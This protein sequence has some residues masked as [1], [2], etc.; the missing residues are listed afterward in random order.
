[1]IICIQNIQQ[2]YVRFIKNP[3]NIRTTRFMSATNQLEVTNVYGIFHS[4]IAEFAFF[5]SAF[6]TFSKIDH[7][8][9]HKT[10]LSKFEKIEIIQNMES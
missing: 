1:M 2:L 3:Q 5:L 6:G 7:I 4:T 10:S 8:L 9:S